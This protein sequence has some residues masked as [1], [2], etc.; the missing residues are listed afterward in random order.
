MKSSIKKMGILIAA[1]GLLGSVNAMAN[2]PL[3]YNYGALQFVNQD[4]DDY[5]CNQDGLRV[6]GSLELNSDF[7]AVG[8]FSDLS[9]G[10]CG[11]DA[12]SIG[13][14][15]HT[16]F[17]ADSSLYGTLS[18]E[19]IDVD[20]GDSDSG[21][22]AAVGLRGF[23]DHKVEAKVQLAHHTAFDG[24]TVLSGGIAYWFANRF[25]ATADVGLGTES[26]EIGLG[27]RMNF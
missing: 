21:L 6:S 24:N 10:R 7:F 23:I 11:S 2:S 4:V 8:S 18:A 12:L 20:Y 27:V 3:S 9:D 17:G 16:L 25:A 22:V 26:S 15:Y 19:N 14:G 13:I 1:A 5:D